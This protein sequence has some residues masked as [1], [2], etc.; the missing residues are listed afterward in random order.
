M[1]GPRRL[2]PKGGLAGPVKAESGAPEP[3]RLRIINGEY[4]ADD[5]RRFTYFALITMDES[6][7]CGGS[8]ISDKFILTAG[9]CVSG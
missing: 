1:Q 6:A 3:G 9:Q 7:L 5:D 2:P 8:I 4:A